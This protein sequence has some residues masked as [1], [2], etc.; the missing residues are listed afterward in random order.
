MIQSIIVKNK[1]L[2]VIG[3]VFTSNCFSMRTVEDFYKASLE[4]KE[5]HRFGRFK[6]N[7][8]LLDRVCLRLGLDSLPGYVID[9]IKF[10]HARGETEQEV[11]SR[12]PEVYKEAGKE[13]ETKFFYILENN[14]YYIKNFNVIRT[15]TSE[16][17]FSKKACQKEYDPFVGFVVMGP[18]WCK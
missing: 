2:F 15:L 8:E 10:L 6:I 9:G 3:L 17:G 13:N 14:G 18:V 16:E 11:L 4:Y 5:R 7:Q 1:L 12:I